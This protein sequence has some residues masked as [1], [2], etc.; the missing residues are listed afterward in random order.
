[1]KPSRMAWIVT[2]IL[3]FGLSGSSLALD[4]QSAQGSTSGSSVVVN[5]GIIKYSPNVTVHSLVSRPDTDVVEFSNGGRLSVAD[6]RRL[7]AAQQK[8]RAAKPG[9]RLPAA[10]KVKPAATGKLVNTPADLS[11]ALKRSDNET[12]RLPSG[13]LVTVGQIKVVQ[14]LVEKRLGRS[15]AVL[16]K[17]Q[18]L[19]GPA[20]KISKSTT[21]SEWMAIF[22]KPDNTIIES[23]NGKRITVGRL[24]QEM[25]QRDK[26]APRRTPPAS[27]QKD[28]RR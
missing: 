22:Q 15:L 25:I 26:A 12:V 4:K 17:E 5:S 9:S 19:S 10:L 1:M 24:K 7:Q 8:M 3:L 28:L 6:I 23:P 11:A 2:A 16:P 14:P 20:I 27:T 21:K 13:R 18:D